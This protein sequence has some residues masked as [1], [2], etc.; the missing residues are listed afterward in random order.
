MSKQVLTRYTVRAGDTLG[1][2]AGRFGTS[3]GA[4]AR[5]NHIANPNLIRV[6]QVLSVPRPGSIPP[7][8]SPTHYTVQPGDTLG[9]IAARFHTSVEAIAH[10]NHIANPNLIHVGQVL[11][12]SGSAVSPPPVVVVTQR[13]PKTTSP[14]GTSPK[15][16]SPKE[17]SAATSAGT[18]LSR[19]QLVTIMPLARPRAA[20]YLPHLNVAMREAAMTS[21]LR[22]AAFLAQLAHESAQLQFMEELASGAEYEGRRDLGNTQPGD[23]VRFK[24]RG[25]IQLTGRNNYRAAGRFLGID[26]LAN[27]R[28][29]ADPDV[30]F[31]VAGWFWTTRGLNDLADRRQFD[32]ITRRINGGLNGK[33]ER[34]RYYALALRVLGA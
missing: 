22:R 18:D 6:G 5:L 34:D 32:A 16:A 23:G 24:G 14:K 17:A 1:A 26:L 7:P 13:G 27:P 21:A 12:L 15:E 4:L 20:D 2:I 31:R 30:G 19:V 33:A 9:A 29:A 8:P 11:Q 3:T 10:A 25:P 28:R